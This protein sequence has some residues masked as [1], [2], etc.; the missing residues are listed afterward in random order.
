MKTYLKIQSVLIEVDNMRSASDLVVPICSANN[1][2]ARIINIC[3]RYCPPR[4]KGMEF[5]IQL[6]E[7]LKV[8][9]HGLGSERAGVFS[10]HFAYDIPKSRANWTPPDE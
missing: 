9:H 10:F 8:I 2:R 3:N 5:S 4:N 1:C 7:S 6:F